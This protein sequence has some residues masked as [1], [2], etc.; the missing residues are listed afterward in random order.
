MRY[1]KFLVLCIVPILGCEKQYCW[2][3]VIENRTDHSITIEGY[4]RLNITQ[5]GLNEN[6][7]GTVEFIK[8]EPY[9][10]HTVLRARGF[11]SDPIGIFENMGIDSVNIY[12]DAEKV[13]SQYCNRITH[14]R[15]C[16]IERNICGYD[17]EYIKTKTGR[18]SGENEYRFTYIIT[19]EDYNNAVPIKD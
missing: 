7:D 12:F 6:I 4:D 5:D 18:S 3:Y 19:E 11:Q 10:F 8:I 9:Q 2:E 13:I 15:D 16:N 17:T 14:L 1:F